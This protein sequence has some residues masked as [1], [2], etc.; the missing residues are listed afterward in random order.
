MKLNERTMLIGET[1]S[2]VPYCKHHVEKYHL[3]M[4]D[5]DLQFLT[6]SEP[7]TLS[8]EYE[9]QLSWQTDD[10]KLTFLAIQGNTIPLTVEEEISRMIGDINLLFLFSPEIAEI[11]MMVAEHKFR[12]SGYGSEMLQLMLCFA[13]ENLSMKK[14]SAKISNS[15]QPS[16]LFFQKHN[17][18]LESVSEVFQETNFE[19]LVS[20]VSQCSYKKVDYPFYLSMEPT[21]KQCL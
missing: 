1:I 19:L 3:W 17:F 10:D 4:Q 16:M 2:F 6:A 13:A 8:E 18:Q 9:M 7:L 21:D 12:R 20:D 5:K 14:F 15:N 11:N